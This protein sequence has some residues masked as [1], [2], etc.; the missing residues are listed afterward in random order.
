[1][2]LQYNYYRTYDPSTGRY[3]ESDPVGLDGGLNTYG[4]GLQNPFKHT[5][6]FGLDVWGFNIGIGAT[7]RAKGAANYAFLVDDDG[8]FAIQRDAETV[9]E[10]T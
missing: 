5:D 9:P 8:N 10:V 4:Y 7:L 1:M 2:Q 3:L 6:K